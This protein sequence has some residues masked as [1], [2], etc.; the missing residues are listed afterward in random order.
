LDTVYQSVLGREADAA[1]AAYW[2][3]LLQSGGIDY[4]GLV[5]AITKDA[6]ANGELKGYATGGLINGPG[7]GTSDSI[8]ARL[9][10][11][12]YVMSADAVRMFGTGL[13]DQMNAGQLPAF[14]TGGPVL[15]VAAPSQVFSSRQSTSGSNAGSESA[16]VAEL[17]GLRREMESNFEYIGRYIKAT[18][19]NTDDIANGVQIHGTVSTKA[20]A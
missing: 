3:G 9:S 17:R 20:V 13:L 8:I 10:N 11:G 15:D 18:A 16:T 4:A 6:K 19:D 1:G 7:T 5:A 12:E 14:A 2:G